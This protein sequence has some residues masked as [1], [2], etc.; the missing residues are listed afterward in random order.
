MG[1]QNACGGCRRVEFSMGGT[2]M[3]LVGCFTI[4]LVEP[5][6]VLTVWVV[7]RFLEFIG[8]CGGV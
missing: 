6:S 4:L 2:A 1:L 8:P 7:V 3:G 5:I